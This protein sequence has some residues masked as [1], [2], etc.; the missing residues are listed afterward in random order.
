MTLDMYLYKETTKYYVTGDHERNKYNSKTYNLNPER[1]SW[2]FF[3]VIPVEAAAP[4]SESVLTTLKGSRADD[5]AL[6]LLIN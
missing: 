2:G 6:T 5:D 4:G 1:M 3:F